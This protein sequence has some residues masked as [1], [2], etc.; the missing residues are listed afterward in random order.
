VVGGDSVS[1]TTG[2]AS[3]ADPNAG[4][5]RPVVVQGIALAGADAGNYTLQAP[6]ALVADITQAALTIQANN[7]NKEEGQ[8]LVFAGTEFTPAKTGIGN[9]TI[10]SVS[11]ASDG[12]VATAAAGAYP[13]KGSGASGSNGFLESNYAI[14]YL[15]GALAVFPTAI[16]QRLPAV[17]QVNNQV[18]TFAALFVQEASTQ[19]S[20][21]TTVQDLKDAKKKKDEGQD[22]VIVNNNV[23]K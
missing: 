8:A 3:F 14:T 4:K 5:A 18:V 6:P 23:C 9:E 19:P 12:A 1:L 2:S 10:T 17:V 16:T 11:L 7:L 22:D 13:I 21:Q 20:E 15:D